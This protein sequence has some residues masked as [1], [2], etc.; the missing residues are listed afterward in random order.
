MHRHD[1]PRPM[2]V[3]S[4]STTSWCRWL[5]H[6]ILTRVWFMTSITMIYGLFKYTYKYIYI[7]I[8]LFMVSKPT[9][10]WGGHHLVW[11]KHVETKTQ[12]P[13]QFKDWN[14]TKQHSDVSLNRLRLSSK[15]LQLVSVTM[16]HYNFTIP[17]CEP[18]CWKIYLHW[19]IFG[20]NVGYR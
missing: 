15:I 18:W 10:Y 5:S 16:K 13:K 19:A 3:R 1:T 9:Y 7:Y 6:L 2:A 8:Y 4:Q 17:R 11:L 12:K 20:V 14:K